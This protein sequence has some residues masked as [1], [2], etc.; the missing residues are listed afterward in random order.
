LFS[1]DDSSFAEVKAAILSEKWLAAAYDVGQKPA[2]SVR[3]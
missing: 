1:L 3:R 2:A